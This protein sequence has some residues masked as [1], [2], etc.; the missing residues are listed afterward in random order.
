MARTRARRPDPEVLDLWQGWLRTHRL[1]TAR[2]DDELRSST[3]M[4]LEEYDVLVQLAQ[5]DQRRLRMSALADALLIARSSCTRLVARLV[6]EGWVEREDDPS[7]GRVVWVSLTA[8]GRAALRRAAIV[9]L[10]GIDEHFAR[11]LQRDDARRLGA[12]VDRLLA[13]DQQS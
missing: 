2:L 12:L 5:S 11:H 10:A 7:D 13:S 6:D 3:G 1:L 4:T 9:H 8:A